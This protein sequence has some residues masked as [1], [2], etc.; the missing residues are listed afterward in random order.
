MSK[1]V[2][3][4]CMKFSF[5]KALFL[6]GAFAL[7]ASNTAFA[8]RG[9]QVGMFAL[10]Q[11]SI[12]Y[13][14]T[15]MSSPKDVYGYR[16]TFGVGVAFLAGYGFTNNLGLR[17]NLMFSDQGQSNT[18]VLPNEE[19]KLTEYTRD[20]RLRYLKLPILFRWNSDPEKKAAATIETGPQLDFLVNVNEQT[21][22][23]VYRPFPPIGQTFTGYPSRSTTFN[24][25]NF[26][27]VL[28]AGVDVKLRYNIKMNIQVRF[29]AGFVDVEKKDAKFLITENGNTIEQKY[30]EYGIYNPAV[31]GKTRGRSTNMTVGLG[32]G[33]Y[34]IFIPRFHY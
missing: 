24:P 10:P 23:K 25:V 32:I 17:A 8:Q 14:A 2:Y 29:D 28:A 19:L 20:L 3:L 31:T 11:Y 16:P 33:F 13:N 30:Y 9:W 7:V 21:S 26:S 22:D 5:I 18:Y 34:Y 4:A 27:W 15:D 12:M 1:V 6:V